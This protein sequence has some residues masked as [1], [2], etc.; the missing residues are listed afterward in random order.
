MYRWAYQLG[1]PDPVVVGQD[2]GEDG[3]VT[4]QQR[5]SGFLLQVCLLEAVFS[6]PYSA[7]AAWLPTEDPTAR[8][9]LGTRTP[10]QLHLVIKREPVA[11][12]QSSRSRPWRSSNA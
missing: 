6:A 7:S 5:L 8:R 1:E 4:E 9:S 2:L 12:H 10:R 11:S 3:W